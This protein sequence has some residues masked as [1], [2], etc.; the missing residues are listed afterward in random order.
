MKSFL[1]STFT[2]FFLLVR[3]RNINILFKRK[4]SSKIDTSSG[5]QLTIVLVN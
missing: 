1:S 4:I 2:Q 5:F 3:N